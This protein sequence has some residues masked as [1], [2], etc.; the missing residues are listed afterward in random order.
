[1]GVCVVGGGLSGCFSVVGVVYDCGCFYG[2]DFYSID[3]HSIDSTAFDIHSLGSYSSDSR[4]RSCVELVSLL[5][6]MRILL[7]GK[8]SSAVQGPCH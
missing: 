2:I 1:M 7:A 5:F 4:P 3:I 6:T 8:N